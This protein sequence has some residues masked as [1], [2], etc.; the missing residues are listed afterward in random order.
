MW[1]EWGVCSKTCDGGTRTRLCNNPP[2]VGSGAD[3]VGE[4]TEPCGEPFCPS[5]TDA[6]VSGSCHK[7]LL[8]ILPFCTLTLDSIK[9][10][11]AN[12]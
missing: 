11:C 8:T 5:K 6:Q 7:F 12:F 9:I 1:G 4:A 3:C 2:P 10:L